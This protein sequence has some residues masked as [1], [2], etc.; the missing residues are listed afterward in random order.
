[1][2]RSA[3]TRTFTYS[4]TSIIPTTTAVHRLTSLL[5]PL[6]THQLRFSTMS[7]PTKMKAC[8]I[9]EQGDLD[10]INVHEIDVPEPG[11]G[12]VL[13]KTEYAG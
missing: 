12:Q 6:L 2:L 9:K 4:R 11:P 5:S 8:Q 1:M 10:V 3:A 13:I 7:L